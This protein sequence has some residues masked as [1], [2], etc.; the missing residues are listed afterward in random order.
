MSDKINQYLI[1]MDMP[2]AKIKIKINK[3]DNY[4]E[5]GFDRC[6][7]FAITNKGEE[8]KPI[9]QIASGGEISRI[10]LS[11][12]L[13]MEKVRSLNTL[14]FDEVDTGVSG[15]TASNIGHLLNKLSEH[16]QLIIVTHLPQIA[17]RSDS[18]IYV[19]KKECNNRI[20]S[21]A[22]NLKEDDHSS[23]IARML[24]GKKI[25]DHSIRQAKEMIANG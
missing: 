23:E 4:S 6:E 21:I 18:H 13:V 22:K 3:L 1:D 17:S 2:D 10:M 15:M 8:Y 5:K 25:T 20:I 11:I 14:V 9:K 24:S 19:Y 7:I 16:R 12:N